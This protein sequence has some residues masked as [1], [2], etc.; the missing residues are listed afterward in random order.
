MA[1]EKATATLQAV[2]KRT[3]QGLAPGAS[4]KERELRIIQS[5]HD[6]ESPD[7]SNLRAEF[8]P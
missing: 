2:C 4:A 8:V 3:V 5:K 7:T 1:L 6:I